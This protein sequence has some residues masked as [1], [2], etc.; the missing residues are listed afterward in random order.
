MIF[1]ITGKTGHGK[2]AYMT[3]WIKQ[4]LQSNKRVYLNFKIYP[5]RMFG[6]KNKYEEGNVKLAED[7]E[8]P[9]KKILYWVDYTDWFL[10]NNGIIFCDEGIIYFNARLWENLPHE[11]QIKLVQHR[12]DSLDLVLN[13]QHYTFI[14]KTI[15]M[16]A[17]RY[18]NCELKI[19]SARFKKSIIPRISKIVEY[20]LPTLN[21]CEN[22]GID[23]YNVL[24][25][26]SEK[27]NIKPFW[28]E[29]FWIKEKIFTW[30]NTSEQVAESMPAPLQH[31]L[32]IC[33]VCGKEQITHR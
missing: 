26:E 13:V 31:Q 23:P 21:R 5:E 12:K 11:I 24:K 28:S 32:R 25:E 1:V 9:N 29:W 6:T 33:S 16:L 8:N 27:Y 10:I 4:A 15:R 18:I 3:K 20:D 7:R 30:Y 2:T 17:E 14:D 22:L 19:G